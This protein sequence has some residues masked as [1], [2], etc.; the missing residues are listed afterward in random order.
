M[1]DGE[2]VSVTRDSIAFD[3]HLFPFTLRLN[4]AAPNWQTFHDLNQTAASGAR[5]P[6]K[7]QCQP[8]SMPPPPPQ[9]ENVCDESDFD[10]N[11]DT[12]NIDSDIPKDSA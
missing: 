12:M 5:A 3:P 1:T 4:A 7:I 6:D 10:P 9:D 11:F 2:T 8:A